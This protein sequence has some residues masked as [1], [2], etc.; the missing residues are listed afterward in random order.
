[1]AYD[2]PIGRV[3]MFGGT[4]LTNGRADAPLLDDT[5]EYD[6]SAN[7]WTKLNPTGGVPPARTASCLVYDPSTE[8][9]ILF[10]GQGT[11]AILN[12]TWA[13]DPPANT[14]TDLD[15]TGD[16]PAARSAEQMAYDPF[17][18]EL[19]MFGGT[20]GGSSLLGDLWAYDPLGNTWT[21]LNPSGSAPAARDACSLVYDPAAEEVILF[22]GTGASGELSD[23]WGYNPGDGTWTDLNPSGVPPARHDAC[24]AYDD[25]TH[26]IILF[27]G[28]ER[29]GS[30]LNDTWSYDATT[31]TWT[32]L[33][34]TGTLPSERA[35]ASLAHDDSL[36]EMILF[37]GVQERAAG[38]G[39]GL[40][41]TWAYT[42]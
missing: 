7:A 20:S 36:D 22:G 38:G 18:E 28:S 17:E 27:G 8:R 25:N 30:G 14:W 4:D 41:D 12:D 24:M 31:N 13:Y 34:P 35:L 21:N 40:H 32:N 23:T 37:G 11:G 19:I 42:P 3:I 2:V 33:H 10:G 5:W 6:P 39:A 1:M 29:T 26:Q 16:L 15:P 9:V